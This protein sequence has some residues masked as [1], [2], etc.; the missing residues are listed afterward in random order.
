MSLS[1]ICEIGKFPLTN[2]TVIGD[3]GYKPEEALILSTK[4]GDWVG[5]AFIEES[6]EYNSKTVA[7]LLAAHR[8][9]L[10]EIPEM[11]LLDNPLLRVPD[12][13]RLTKPTVVTCVDSG[14]L[15]IY[16]Q[17]HYHKPEI[18]TDKDDWHLNC[19][20]DKLPHEKFNKF[21]ISEDVL[22]AVLKLGLN[23][24]DDNS[25]SREER[26]EASMASHDLLNLGLKIK[27]YG[28]TG[29]P[30][31]GLTVQS[32]WGDGSYQIHTH[33]TKAGVDIILVDFFHI[34]GA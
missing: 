6:D 30:V 27:S 23:R 11:A 10:Q 16:Q 5:Y 14:M 8:D 2:S 7:Y 18:F 21:L 25:L 34:P 17:E 26:L 20:Y 9:L 28:L 1:S 29:H 3:P 13:A 31:I 15:G 32:G 22:D 19:C 12:L 24:W 4:A 33:D